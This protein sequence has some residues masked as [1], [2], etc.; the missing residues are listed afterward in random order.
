MN[1]SFEIRS[2]ITD[3]AGASLFVEIGQHGVSYWVI[4]NME[5]ME[6]VVYH[7]PANAPYDAAANYL[8]EVVSANPVLQ[9]PFDKINII[10]A[11]PSAVLVP[12]EYM[13]H[14]LKKNIL[15]MVYGDAQDVTIKTDYMYR[16]Q[17]YNV[18]SVPKQVD[19][20]VAYLLSADN[21]QH[22]YSLLPDI[23][24]DNNNNLYCIFNNSYF[25][26]MLQK[27]GKLQLLQTYSYKTP[28]DAAY[29]MLQLCESF[30]VK[31]ASIQL[32]LNGMID[33]SSSLYHEI[34]KYFLE[35][36][37]GS[38]PDDYSYPEAIQEYPAHFFSHLFTMGLCV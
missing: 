15:E 4:N 32:Y 8:K 23:L 31:P 6:L 27:E 5:C 29:Y 2:S 1:P 14:E 3:T 36:K 18:Y 10:Y 37:F 9:E 19:A 35:I 7:F 38:L 26:V 12:Y 13:K 17:L 34:S 24:K 16:H 22:Q 33:L 20:T 25:T 21:C 30:G 11:Y 28:E